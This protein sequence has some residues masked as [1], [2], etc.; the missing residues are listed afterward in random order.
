MVESALRVLPCRNPQLIRLCMFQRDSPT[1]ARA[2]L[3]TIQDPTTHSSPNAYHVE[4]MGAKVSQSSHYE[5][6]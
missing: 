5:S 1:L 4:S 3:E 6:K 2:Q